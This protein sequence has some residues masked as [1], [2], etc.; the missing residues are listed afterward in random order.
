MAFCRSMRTTVC[1]MRIASQS[2]ISQAESKIIKTKLM[3]ILGSEHTAP[4]LGFK[5]KIV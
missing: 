5:D 4:R 3:Y 2:L 1:F